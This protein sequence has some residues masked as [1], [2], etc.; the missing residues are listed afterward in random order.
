MF[1]ALVAG[2]LCIDLAPRLAQPPDTRQGTLTEVGPLGISVGGCVANT[3]GDLAALGAPVRLAADVGDDELGDILRRGLAARTPAPAS[4]V[5]LSGATTSY[6]VVVQPPGADRAFWHHVGANGH[7]DGT[8][9]E[10]SGE[11]LLHLGYPSVLP[12]LLPETGRPLRDLLDRARRAGLTTSVDLAVVDTRP[13]AGRQD[14]PA[15]LAHCL[16]LVD[17]LSP[18]VD[19]LA[20]ALHRAYARTPAA[21]SHAAAELIDAGVAVV[22]LT[23]GTDG[24]LLR[25]AG[26]DRLRGGGRV[27]AARAEEWADREMWVPALPVDQVRTTGAGDAATAGLL[28]ALLA[29]LAPEAA[30]VLA[31][32][33]AAE[34]VS[35]REALPPYGDGSAYTVSIPYRRE[36]GWTRGPRGALLGPRDRAG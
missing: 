25:S 22:L 15:I 20:S 13:E 19:D 30:A 31:A 9:V 11:D 21:L 33:V 3:G 18:S 10:L 29:G 8:R 23:A 14:W 28:Y 2:H 26:P 27:L 7:F 34:H 24:L 16:P 17:L 6:T 4:L 32:A 1:R 35:G 5:T 12:A 36:A